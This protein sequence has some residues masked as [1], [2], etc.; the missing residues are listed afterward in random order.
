MTPERGSAPIELKGIHIDLVDRVVTLESND[1][2]RAKLS[3][4]AP[5]TL[6][7]PPFPAADVAN[8]EPPEPESSGLDQTAN[9]E[10]KESEP[11]VVVT[12]SLRSAPKAGR[13]DSRGRPTAWAAFAAHQDGADDAHLY[14][15]TFHRHTAA[16]ALALESGTQITAEGYPHTNWDPAGKRMDTFSVVNLLDYPGKPIKQGRRR[17]SR[18]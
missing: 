4:G 10:R 11:T 13:Q 17:R 9:A 3:F 14:G 8:E 1:G 2:R 16:I 18:N 5:A 12:G 7:E 6:Y 15:A